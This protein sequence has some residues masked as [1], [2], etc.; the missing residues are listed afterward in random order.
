MQD[1]NENQEAPLLIHDKI[2]W[3]SVNDDLPP[4]DVEVSAYGVERGMFSHKNKIGICKFNPSTGWSGDLNEVLFWG[5]K[6]NLPVT[7]KSNEDQDD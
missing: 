7:K 6:I 3:I 4:Y 1:L 5:E 2:R